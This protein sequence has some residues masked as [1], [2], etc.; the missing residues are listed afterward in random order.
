MF[1][2]QLLLF[3]LCLFHRILLDEGLRTP[4][5]PPMQM[6]PY[7][8]LSPHLHYGSPDL[9]VLVTPTNSS[10]SQL[11]NFPRNSLSPNPDIH[12]PYYEAYA[13][14][15]TGSPP[16]P[17]ME[18]P[19]LDIDLDSS[20][21]RDTYS[22]TPRDTEYETHQSDLRSNSDSAS[23]AN[24]SVTSHDLAISLLDQAIES[25]DVLL[26]PDHSSSEASYRP[27]SPNSDPRSRD[28]L[29]RSVAE[30]FI[31]KLVNI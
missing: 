5:S 25:Y 20:T 11:E 28:L 26:S 9:H 13:S 23:I 12:S 14:L 4:P 16:S 24:Q 18:K 19:S 22:P 6:S 29:A 8:L 17:N 3:S 30:A 15:I 10:S 21:P 7:G 27:I 1:I 31:A 2:Q